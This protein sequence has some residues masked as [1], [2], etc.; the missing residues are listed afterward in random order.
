MCQE[1]WFTFIVICFQKNL[2]DKSFNP[3]FTDEETK[4]LC[5]TQVPTYSK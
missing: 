4:Q 3:H 1:L 2:L 5:N